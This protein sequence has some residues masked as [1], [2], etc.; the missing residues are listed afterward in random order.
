[1]L[2]EDI[3]IRMQQAGE[4]LDVSNPV[5][6]QAEGIS[7][8][9]RKLD[10]APK[11]IKLKTI[12]LDQQ[13]GCANEF[14]MMYSEY[15]Q[16][17]N[18]EVAK[19]QVAGNVRFCDVEVYY[20]LHC[21]ALCGI[22][23]IPERA[24]AASDLFKLIITTPCQVLTAKA[25]YER[26]QSIKK[27]DYYTKQFRTALSA[28]IFGDSTVILYWL[29]LASDHGYYENASK[30]GAQFIREKGFNELE[31]R[32]FLNEKYAEARA[33]LEFMK[34]LYKPMCNKWMTAM[35]YTLKGQSPE[36]L[37]TTGSSEGFL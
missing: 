25:V 21:L 33:D 4:A 37:Q 26:L 16:S 9:P 14:I 27:P 1:M 3:L 12:D 36:V 28:C 30:C 23:C 24:T 18:L 6:L 29:T 19:I 10:K 7:R 32:K 22:H 20:A 2:R 35:I 13:Y 11:P 17:M 31:L 8:L 15:K 34:Q 5:Y